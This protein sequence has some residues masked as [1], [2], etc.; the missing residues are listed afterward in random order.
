M[1]GKDELNE[2]ILADDY[3]I[4]GDYLYVADGRVV[5]SDW[6]G[7]VGRALYRCT[8]CGENEINARANGCVRGPCP[9]EF[10]G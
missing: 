3:P 9:M 2:P 1:R 7:G 10:I 8:R 5:R 4:Y 6:P